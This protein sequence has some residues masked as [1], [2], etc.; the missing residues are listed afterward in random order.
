MMD[1]T[2]NEAHAQALLLLE[3]A[4]VPL[5]AA[6]AL[7]DKHGFELCFMDKTYSPRNTDESVW[8]TSDA[9]EGV[10]DFYWTESNE[11]SWLSSSDRC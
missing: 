4:R 9:N 8:T 1:I 3:Q 10:L 7:A 5:K 6:Q 2:K 11:G